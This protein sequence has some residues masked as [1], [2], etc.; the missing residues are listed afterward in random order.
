[1][2][3]TGA[4]ATKALKEIKRKTKWSFRKI[5]RELDISHTSVCSLHKGHTDNPTQ[6]FMDSIE[7][8]RAELI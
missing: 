1:M 7:A 3:R 8:L 4:E 6:Q 2:I 5:A